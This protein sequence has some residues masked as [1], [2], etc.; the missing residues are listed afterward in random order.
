M[1]M[2]FCI[3]FFAPYYTTVAQTKDTTVAIP[4][5]EMWGWYRKLYCSAGMGIG[6]E[7]AITQNDIITKYELGISY[8]KTG[9]CPITYEPMTYL[10]WLDTKLGEIYKIG[11]SYNF[12]L[13][14]NIP[15]KTTDRFK[16]SKYYLEH[17]SFETGFGFKKAEVNYYPMLRLSPR[18]KYTLFNFSELGSY[19]NIYPFYSFDINYNS[20]IRI[21]NSIGIKLIWQIG[22]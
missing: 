14:T 4:S 11:A 2:F 15:H 1:K 21:D 7:N 20:K 6:L 18:F 9:C 19:L 22:F 10:L 12:V 5:F 16:W 13:R 3:L 8:K 17:F